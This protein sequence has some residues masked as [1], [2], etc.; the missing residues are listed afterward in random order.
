VA[1]WVRLKDEGW[2]IE[3]GSGRKYDGSDGLGANMSGT[4]AARRDWT[5][6]RFSEGVQL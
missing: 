6:S 2:G 1:T 4:S 5:E 3:C